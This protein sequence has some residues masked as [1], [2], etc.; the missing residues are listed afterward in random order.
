MAAPFRFHS[1]RRFQIWSY[2]ASH[3]RL[4]VRSPRADADPTRV[5]IMFFGVAR[6]ELDTAMDGVSILEDLARAPDRHGEQRRTYRVSSPAN[7]GWVVAESVAVHEDSREW[8]ERS[9]LDPQLH[10]ERAITRGTVYEVWCHDG[11]GLPALVIV[12]KCSDGFTVRESH[13]DGPLVFRDARY[14][15]VRTWLE[16][17]R[18]ELL[19]QR[20][21]PTA[22]G[23]RN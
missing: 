6:M 16:T 17:H 14:A 2:S 9:A 23:P 19:A 10:S 21:E 1:S 22:V 13:A 11:A 20:G 12:R 7:D 3:S 18:Y 8:W 4:L 15:T 5:D